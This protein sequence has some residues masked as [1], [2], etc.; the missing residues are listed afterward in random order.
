MTID[1][2]IGPARG[3]AVRVSQPRDALQAMWLPQRDAILDAWRL[4]D[5]GHTRSVLVAGPYGPVE[6]QPVTRHG[7]WTVHQSAGSDSWSVSLG[8]IGMLAAWRADR[9][10]AEAIAKRLH[11]ATPAS[12]D[13]T[14][15]VE[16]GC[17]WMMAAAR[18]PAEGDAV[19]VEPSPL[20]SIATAL[21]M[22]PDA[23]P[24]AIVERVEAMVGTLADAGDALSAIGFGDDGLVDRVRQVASHV[25][26]LHRRAQRAESR[27][28]SHARSIAKRD[29]KIAEHR[30]ALDRIGAAY[31]LPPHVLASALADLV[32]RDRAQVDAAP[33]ACDLLRA[34]A[35]DGEG[36]VDTVRRLLR[37]RDEAVSEG[38][39]R[40]DNADAELAKMIEDRDAWKHAAETR[41]TRLH[42]VRD[43][44]GARDDET[45]LDAA[46]RV[47][48]DCDAHLV[49][50]RDRERE[51]DE[52]RA[53]RDR[54]SAI[55]AETRRALGDAC[56][57]DLA[58]DVRRVVAEL[59]AMHKRDAG[60][61]RTDASPLLATAIPA[62]RAGINAGGSRPEDVQARI[63]A[64][65]ALDGL[66]Q[67]Q[68]LGV[69]LSAE[70]DAAGR[71][72]A[73]ERRSE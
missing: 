40:L 37:G 14:A 15:W 3:D 16:R 58:A 59:D 6:V 12:F 7:V 32:E 8:P 49:W 4:Y 71:P 25:R 44:L 9:G 47:S 5:A 42:E 62:I 53:Q 28:A 38:E 20:A 18:E 72:L 69:V 29:A 31:G 60:A 17:E 39:R 63:G 30:A 46:R 35:L 50:V 11:D 55:I 45:T 13:P 68:S 48:S 36:V 56:T 51:R 67:G 1:N 73:S 52:A 27:A 26:R 66:A 65:R 33:I 2:D 24:G 21:G 43:V 10:E 41:T 57:G 22:S 64:H 70:D 54:L 61:F 19:R 34:E 23:L